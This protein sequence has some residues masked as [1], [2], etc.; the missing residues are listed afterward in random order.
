MI[1]SLLTGL[2]IFVTASGCHSRSAEESF[3]LF[4][5][6]VMPKGRIDR[7]LEGKNGAYAV[8]AKISK[9]EFEDFRKRTTE[10]VNWHVLEAGMV[11]EIGGCDISLPHDVK[12]IYSVGG[13][14]DGFARVIVWDGRSGFLAAIHATGVM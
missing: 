14:A 2:G 9:P 11:F 7:V 6:E 4:F 5:G 1:R 12:G 13:N 3:R 10:F 8:F